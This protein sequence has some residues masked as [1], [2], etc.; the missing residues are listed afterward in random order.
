L[1]R[2]QGAQRR[3]NWKLRRPGNS[4]DDGEHDLLAAN[5]S[6]KQQGL[7]C[8]FK[9]ETSSEELLPSSAV[10]CGVCPP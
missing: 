3:A 8:S 5:G 1:K 2:S 9:T 10:Q 4:S 6:Y 7:P